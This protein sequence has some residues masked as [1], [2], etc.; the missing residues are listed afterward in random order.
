MGMIALALAAAFA[1]DGAD[2]LRPSSDW[3][4]DYADNSCTLSRSF[5]TGEE[6]VS[7]GLMPQTGGDRIRV[8]LVAKN[9]DRFAGEGRVTIAMGD[10]REPAIL[11]Y[12][13]VVAPDQGRVALMRMSRIV[14]AP[15]DKASTLTFNLGGSTIALAVPQMAAALKALAA[16]ETDLAK[17]WGFD[18]SQIAAPPTPAGAPSAGSPMPTIPPRRLTRRSGGRPCCASRS[19]PR[20]SRWRARSPMAAARRCSIA[21]PAR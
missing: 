6:M 17:S 10:G 15:L 18:L 8:M 20:A 13:S 12:Y 7:L 1:P 21:H 9:R 14:L 4:V 2:M 5:G 16:C 19:I 3:A 11:H